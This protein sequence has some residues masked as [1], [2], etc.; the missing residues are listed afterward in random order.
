MD[1]STNSQSSKKVSKEMSEVLN[2]LSGEIP[3]DRVK[4]VRSLL[5]DRKLAEGNVRCTW[6]DGCYYCQDEHG[7]WK[8][9]SCYA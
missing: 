6:W 1:K 4:E 9:V 8:L 3:K 7:E 5:V 2:R